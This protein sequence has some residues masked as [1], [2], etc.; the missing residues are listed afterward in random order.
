MMV[1]ALDSSGSMAG[2]PFKAVR[3]A[4]LMI[5]TN[6]FEAQMKP[7]EHLNTIIYNTQLKCMK[8]NTKN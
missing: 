5:F 3:E 6:I 4:A 7:F 8:Y 1:I 2:R